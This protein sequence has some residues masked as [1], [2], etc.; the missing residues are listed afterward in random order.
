MSEKTDGNIER[1]QAALAAIRAALAEDGVGGAAGDVTALALVPAA[2]RGRATIQV[3]SPG[4]V[5][6]LAVARMVFREVDPDVRFEAAAADGDR[7][8][9][10][11]IVAR[12]TSA[13]EMHTAQTPLVVGRSV[14]ALAA[15][16][17]LMQRSGS[18]QW[19]EDLGREFGLVDEFGRP[20]A[21]YA[22]RM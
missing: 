7:I 13:E 3:K 1:D 16:T 17:D 15:A 20:P 8:A 19:V 2:A 9:T 6:G 22:K 5:A 10:R 21:P 11:T 18:I 12:G 14:A 4:V